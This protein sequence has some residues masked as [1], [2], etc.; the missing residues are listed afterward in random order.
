MAKKISRNIS[1]DVEEEATE[2]ELLMKMADIV[3]RYDPDILT[4][5]EVHN[6]SWGY[7]I[8]R[9]RFKYDFNFCD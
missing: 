5:Y 6:S 9:A 4:G 3:R 7:L 2:L 8:E 1:I